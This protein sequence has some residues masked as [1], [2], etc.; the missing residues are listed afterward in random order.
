MRGY[1][2]EA[3]V[4]LRHDHPT[5]LIENSRNMEIIRIPLWVTVQFITQRSF[6]G[7]CRKRTIK[8]LSTS[9]TNFSIKQAVISMY[10]NMFLRQEIF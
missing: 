4:L 3:G 5:F 7:E 6:P 10:H 8:S 9:S 1:K 2:T